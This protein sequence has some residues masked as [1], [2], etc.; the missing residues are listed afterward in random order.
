VLRVIL[1]RIVRAVVLS[2]FKVV[3]RVSVKGRD[4]VPKNGVYIVAPSHRSILDIPF[5]AFVTKRRIRFMAKRELFSSRIGRVVFNAMG[6]ISVDR[7]N[8]DRAALRESQAALEGGELLSIFP[9]GTRRH[10][11]VL[12][13]LYDGVAY[14]ALKLGVPILPVGV[15]GSEEILASGRVIPRIHKVAVVVGAPII[16][17]PVEGSRRRSEVAALTQELA[18]SLQLCLTE[19]LQRA[20]VDSSLS[21]EGSKSS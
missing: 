2:I 1:Y 9:E 8:T 17:K 18:T 12:G 19:A 4:L 16:P 3:F 13:E 6:A 14:L 20:G 11:P 21:R 7:G 10:G 15:G 5:T